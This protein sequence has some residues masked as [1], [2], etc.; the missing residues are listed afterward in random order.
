MAGGG[1]GRAQKASALL[2]LAVLSLAWTASLV[3][4]GSD[5]ST[6]GSGLLPD[7]S[8]VPAEAV[9]APASLTAP[10]T[11][12]PGLHG[13]RRSVV[14]TAS[15]SGIPAAA[16]TA[17]RRAATIIDAADRSCHLPWQLL[18]AIGRVE[19]DHGRT[20]GNVLTDQGVARPGIYGPALDGTG[21]TSPIRDTDA[22]QY[23]RDPRFDRAVG[24]M[25]FLPSTWSIVGVDADDDGRRDPQ[26]IDDAALG[27]AVYL[28]SGDDDL[29]TD[30]GRRAAVLRYNHSERYV[31]LVLAIL[32]AYLDR[33]LQLGPEQHH[34]D[35]L[36]ARDP[37]GDDDRATTAV[38]PTVATTGTTPLRR[39]P[40]AAPDPGGTGPTSGPTSGPAGGPTDQPTNRADQRR[41][42]HEAADP[43]AHEPADRRTDDPDPRRGDRA[44]SRRRAGRQPPRPERRLRPVRLRPDPL[45]GPAYPTVL[46]AGPPPPVVR[47][48]VR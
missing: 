31:A 3:T 24:P 8:R 33:R 29:G 22:G 36:V 10:R 4:A 23:D 27:S 25:Q 30:A 20:G 37:A 48:T 1:F 43:A 17:Y 28:C 21:G 47:P 40:P 19:S 32:Q 41:S 12:A 9:R 6:A 44:M 35:L 46:R 15:A 38:R 45:T 42:A 14:S 18:A 39:S 13:H 2:P 5:G 11:L 26:D 7:G 34:L 16:L